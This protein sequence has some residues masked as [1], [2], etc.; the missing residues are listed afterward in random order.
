[1]GTAFG[2]P[3]LGRGAGEPGHRAGG[4]ASGLHE[5]PQRLVGWKRGLVGGVVWGDRAGLS[6]SQRPRMLQ[7]S[8]FPARHTWVPATERHRLP[9][10]GPRRGVVQTAND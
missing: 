1:V 5:P 8:W 4:S 10:T 2:A 6:H 7:T 9:G 3:V